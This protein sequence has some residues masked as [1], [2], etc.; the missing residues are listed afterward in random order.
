MVFV[1]RVFSDR[2]VVM[3]DGFDLNIFPVL[4]L[5]IPYLFQTEFWDF[6]LSLTDLIINIFLKF[7][8]S[9][10]IEFHAFSYF[11]LYQWLI[12]SIIFYIW[13]FL[14]CFAFKT[15]PFSL[16]TFSIFQ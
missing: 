3:I 1:N 2:S 12:P 6:Q 15:R 11:Q 7:E 4:H 16:T 10:L 14:N 5:W 9:P 13:G 8:N